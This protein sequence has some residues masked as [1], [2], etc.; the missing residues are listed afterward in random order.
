MIDIKIDTS[1]LRASLKIG[2]T[3]INSFLSNMAKTIAI[4]FAK[5]W[6]LQ[7]KKTLKKT[8]KEYINSIIVGEKDQF[9]STV[10]VIGLL[11][12]MIEQGAESFDMKEG[13]SRS[14]K[15]KLKKDGG[16]FLTIPFRY[17]IPGSIGESENF[18]GILP[19]EVHKIAKKI[20]RPVKRSELPEEFQVKGVRSEMIFQGHLLEEYRHKSAQ[21]EG[22]KRIVKNYEK[23]SQGTY[24]TFRRVSDKSDEGSWIY[25]G[26]SAMHLGDKTLNEI[27]LNSI[28]AYEKD[29][30]IDSL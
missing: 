5:E 10:T 16:W 13:F 2:K 12:N 21:F 22:L 4:E 1:E 8:R 15:K 14:S 26:L 27:D 20:D 9:V 3:Q 17:A 23:V 18:A 19:K 30:F 29:N 28:I 25:P 24:I 11:P 6:K 7:A